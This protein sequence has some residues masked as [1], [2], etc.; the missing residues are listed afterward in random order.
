M[1]I[2][3]VVPAR[4]AAS[5]FPGKPLSQIHGR[6]M[7]EHVYLRGSLYEN[8]D[9]FVIATCDEEIYNYIQG[10]GG[11]GVMTSTKHNRATDRTAEAMMSF[12]K[13]HSSFKDDP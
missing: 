1:K 7:L 6:T 10:I 5:R 11:K 8:W 9:Q 4:M 2:I 12:I 3:G 13:K